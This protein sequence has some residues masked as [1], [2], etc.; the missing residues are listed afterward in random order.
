LLNGTENSLSNEA[1][2]LKLHNFLYLSSDLR[3]SFSIL[4]FTLQHYLEYD[5]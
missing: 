2:K 4:H 5:N 1:I 3:L